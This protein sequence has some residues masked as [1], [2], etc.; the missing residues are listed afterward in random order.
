MDVNGMQLSGPGQGI[1]WLA[2]K[3]PYSLLKV[4]LLMEGDNFDLKFFNFLH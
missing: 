4:F 3:Y 1:N 2:Q